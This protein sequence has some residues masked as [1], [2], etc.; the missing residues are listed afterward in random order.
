MQA[1]RQTNRYVSPGR[2]GRL[3]SKMYD[4][5]RLVDETQTPDLSRQLQKNHWRFNDGD[6]CNVDCAADGDVCDVDCAADGDVCGVD[7]A[8]DGDDGDVDCAA[9]GDVCDVDCAADG[10]V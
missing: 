4:G 2:A 1:D 3:Q 9:D 8:V 5:C 6:V 7:C 10:D